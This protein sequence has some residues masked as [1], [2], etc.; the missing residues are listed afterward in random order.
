MPALPPTRVLDLLLLL[1]NAF[2]TTPALQQFP[3]FYLAHTSQK[4]L[5]ATRT[6][7]EWLS[8]DITIQD[9]PLDFKQVK[10]VTEYSDLA[11]G[12]AGP[13]VVIVDGLDLQ[14]GS[15]A[16]QAFLDFKASGNLLLLT[17]H[18]VSPNST[19]AKLLEQWESS[20]PSI[21]DDT[22]RPIV[23]VTTDVEVIMEQRTPLQ[24]EELVQWK[25]AERQ[26][27]EQKD[28]DLFFEERQRNL[29]EGNESDSEEDEEEDHLILDTSAPSLRAR[30]SAILLQEGSN[31]FW[32]GDILGGRAALKHFPFVDKR[33]RF[34]EWGMTFKPEEFVR[35]ED[36]PLVT[37]GSGAAAAE[38]G[39][40]RKWGE[41]E[42]ETENLPSKVTR[43]VMRIDVNVRVGYVDLEGLHDGRAAGN[44][45][46]RL[47]PRKLVLATA[48][49]VTD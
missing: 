28:A 26:N 17:S 41:V 15:F 25:R 30:G 3:V 44:L 6:M 46:P 1:D 33:K 9:H 20:S 47:N 21:S 10:V 4:A 27:R 18:S 34:D 43:S 22:P 48:T 49:G 35:V 38:L 37:R 29:L 13:R 7:L 40:K 45:L 24:G 19:T 32:M 2:A 16:H 8:Q 42:V 5:S 12:K 11:Q 39:K 31:D 14:V 23:N 36:E